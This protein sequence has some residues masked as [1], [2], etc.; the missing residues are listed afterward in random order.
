MKHIFI[1]LTGIILLTACS[2]P[3]EQIATTD[4]PIKV[5][6]LKD[7]QLN[8][9]QLDAETF[10]LEEKAKEISKHKKQ[11]DKQSFATQTTINM[12]LALFSNSTSANNRVLSN[13]SDAKKRHIQ[14]LM[15][16]HNHLINLAKQKK[17]DFVA[18]TEK[19]IQNYLKPQNKN[20]V[21][22]YHRRL[23]N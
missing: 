9:T 13:Y 8:C 15:Q 12:V 5:S 22:N 6:L 16:R 1:I 23:T 3:N 19:R 11:Q 7:N 17:C 18:D 2:T 14:S 10:S 4:K 20:Q 21:N